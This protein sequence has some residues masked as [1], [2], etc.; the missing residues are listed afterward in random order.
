MTGTI[1][2]SK[3][4]TIFIGQGVDVFAM[5]ALASGLELYANAG[6]IPNRA[7]TPMSMLA[8]ANKWTGAKFKRGQ[9]RSAAAALRAKACEVRVT[10]K[11]TRS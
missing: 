7:Y 10:L 5:L 8:L 9:Y 1:E 2:H 3:G 6:I 4:G 11:E